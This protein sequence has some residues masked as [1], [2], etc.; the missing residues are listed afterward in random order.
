M[1]AQGHVVLYTNPRGSTS[2]GDEL[3]NMIHHAY[4]GDD[5]FGLNSGVDAVVAQGYVDT[6]NLFVTGGSGGGVLTCWMVDRTTR[7]RAAISLYPAINWT[8]W[9]LTSDIPITGA[10]YWFPGPPVDH[11]EQYTARSVLS[12][13]NKVTTPTMLMVG[14]EDWPARRLKRSSFTQ[15]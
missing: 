15:P 12:Y 13:V 2:Y 4:P 7:F 10:K 6:D 3:G 14:E 8:S 9:T 5:F 1:A 11:Q